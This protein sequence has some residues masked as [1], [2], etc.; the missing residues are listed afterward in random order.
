MLMDWFE[1]CTRKPVY[2]LLTTL[3]VPKKLPGMGSGP[4]DEFVPYNNT[5]ALN[6]N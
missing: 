3:T 5:E 6:R 4:P 1:E 2:I